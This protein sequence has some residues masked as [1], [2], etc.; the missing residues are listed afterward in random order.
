MEST[1]FRRHLGLDY[2]F[3]SSQV[4]EEL[5]HQ[6]SVQSSNQTVRERLRGLSR[7]IATA[8]RDHAKGSTRWLGDIRQSCRLEEAKQLAEQA[9]QFKRS[10]G[11]IAIIWHPEGHSGR[12]FR[13][14]RGEAP[15]DTSEESCDSDESGAE[16]EETEVGH[17]HIYHT[18]R[19]NGS[20]CR[21]RFLRG[22][23]LKRR[24]GRRP[25]R[26]SDVNEKH[27]NLWLQY[28]LR[29]PRRFLHLAIGEVDALSEI[30]QIG[31]LRRSEEVQEESSDAEMEDGLFPRV[32]ARRKPLSNR[33]KQEDERGSEDSE[34]TN[35]STSSIIPGGS[36]RASGA[37]KQRIAAHRKLVRAIEDFVCVPFYSTCELS[38]WLQNPELSFFD[39]A[40]PDYK[41]AVSTVSRKIQH[42]NCHQ[43]MTLVTRVTANPVWYAR[44]D[45]H[46]LPPDVSLTMCIRL[47]EEQ[48]G[49]DSIGEF[50]QRLMHI[51]EKVEPKRNTMLI[52]GPPNCGKTWFFD[53]VCAFYLNVGHIAN[54]V[55]GEHFPLNDCIGRRIL[56]W[57]EPS[58]MPSAFDTVKMIT[59]G[60]PCPANVKYQGHSVI[61]RTPL[62][63]TGNNR[64]FPDTEVWTS[65]VY[66]EHWHQAPFLKDVRGY[67]VPTTL[68]KLFKLYGVI[69]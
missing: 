33:G 53:M 61:S 34:A 40:D 45:S 31:D 9:N 23:R 55:R 57:N 32:D 66:T 50:L 6:G 11:V 67:P 48:Y 41:R 30:H 37:L 12:H 43:I 56:M 26:S 65:R 21:C 1:G 18:C 64:V 15:G 3:E 24:H 22:L 27:C 46:Y 44:T 5:Q 17:V 25:I 69:E 10:E 52:L 29:A 28:F 47:L 20:Y 16:Y 49:Q 13:R 8:I 19:F 54:F 2:L 36:F 7:R 38:Q 4:A 14:R 60:D 62:I 63:M 68:Y 51:C 59:G 58:I 35:A 42:L 39:K